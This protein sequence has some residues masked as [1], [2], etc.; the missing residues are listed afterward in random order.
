MFKRFQKIADLSKAGFASDHLQG[1]HYEA[2]G[3]LLVAV[4][5]HV[6]GRLNVLLQ[7]AIGTPLPERAYALAGEMRIPEVVGAIKRLVAAHSTNDKSIRAIDDVFMEAETLRQARDVVAHKSVWAK[8]DTLS[9]HNAF[10]ARSE[11]RVEVQYFT[12][13]ELGEFAEYAVRLG[14][15]ITALIPL[16]APKPVTTSQ[17]LALAT[18]HSTVLL[19]AASEII[20]SGKL[21]KE[22]IKKIRAVA[23]SSHAAM[24]RFRDLAMDIPSEAHDAEQRAHDGLIEFLM[25]LTGIAAPEPPTL[26][27]IPARLQTNN[28]RREA[29]QS[30]RRPPSSSPA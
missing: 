25:C 6:D 10:V 3:R 12:I 26:L 11:Q 28:R 2:I 14:Y 1:K 24:V 15:R 9:F 20:K 5:E 7:V 8:G 30:P 13:A 23:D 18:I 19:T 16:V 17:R 4:S 22:K 21:S 29:P 27:E